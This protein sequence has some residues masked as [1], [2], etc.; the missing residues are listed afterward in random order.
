M[1]QI[2]IA[3]RGKAVVLMGKNTMVHC[4]LC[5]LLGELPQFEC[6]IPHIKGNI[7]FVFTNEDLKEVR[8]LMAGD[9]GTHLRW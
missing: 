4:A 1:H 8:T 3:L 9:P 7:S 5:S 2:C 6:L